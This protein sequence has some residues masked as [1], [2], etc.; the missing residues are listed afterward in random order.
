MR[1]CKSAHNQDLKKLPLKDES[2]VAIILALIML[3]VMSVLAITVSFSSNMDFKAMSNF[4]RGQE[5]FLAAE[6]CVEEGRNR[7]EVIGIETL[8]FLLQNKDT[9]VLSSGGSGNL[10]VLDKDLGNGATCRSGFRDLDSSAG[11]GQLIEIPPISKTIQR[12]LK[13]TSM[14]SSASGGAGYVPVTFVV[15]GKDSRDGDKN[16]T[17]S[18]LNTGTE[19]AVG[20]ETFIPGNAN[21]MYS[22]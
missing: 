15:T 19:I 11:P 12:P 22:Q 6:R 14:S 20:F 13:N 4:K 16:D 2:G 3:L 1:I 17:N 7:F 9:L 8:F 10:L 5:A 18:K 21:Q